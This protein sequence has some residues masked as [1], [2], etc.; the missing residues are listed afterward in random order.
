M[1]MPTEHDLRMLARAAFAVCR[2]FKLGS[3][4]A[5]NGDAGRRAWGHA[6]F[7]RNEEEMLSVSVYAQEKRRHD[8]IT[9]GFIPDTP[10]AEMT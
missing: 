5:G 3:I 8:L 9:R 1:S 2:K 4:A 7:V 6:L 10:T